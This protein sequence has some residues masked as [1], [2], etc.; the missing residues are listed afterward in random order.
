MNPWIRKLSHVNVVPLYK[1]IVLLGL[2]R[3]YLRQIRFSIHNSV[4][5]IRFGSHFRPYRAKN[6]DSVKR[7][8]IGRWSVVQPISGGLTTF[9]SL[10]SVYK[11]MSTWKAPTIKLYELLTRRLPSDRLY[12]NI[13]EIWDRQMYLRIWSKTVCRH[14]KAIFSYKTGST[15]S[16]SAHLKR[17]A[18]NRIEITKSKYINWESNRIVGQVNRY[19][20]SFII[21]VLN[22]SSQVAKKII[23]KY[24]FIVHFVGFQPS[25]CFSL[26]PKPQPAT[27]KLLP[28]IPKFRLWKHVQ[29]FHSELLYWIKS[30]GI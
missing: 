9:A 5:S 21:I 25:S 23:H 14:C 15:T 7:L 8:L 18:E 17:K 24:N 26:L 13:L 29:I 28:T 2:N 6:R 20:P 22:M 10:C 27:P 3:D 19:S 16:M 12:G 4:T 1:G 11:Q 30:R